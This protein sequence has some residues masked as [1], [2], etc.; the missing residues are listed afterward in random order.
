MLKLKC[1]PCLRKIAVIVRF[2]LYNCHVMET[3]NKLD[4]IISHW[5]TVE[6]ETYEIALRLGQERF[7]ERVA[8][9]ESVTNKSIKMLVLNVSLFGWFV[10]LCFSNNIE[11]GLLSLLSV[12]ATLIILIGLIMPKSVRDK[13]ISPAI[14]LP[15]LFDKSH[16]GESQI[17][18]VLF[19]ALSIVQQNI[20]VMSN[21]NS[22][23]ASKYKCALILSMVN[24]V[25]LSYSV[26]I[27]L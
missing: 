19:N 9:S 26:V 7:S 5:S 27:L 10:G 20:D 14:L 25:L 18:L 3:K 1:K 8:E 24:M 4:D 21:L 22:Q 17:K 11:I 16:R 6:K 23:R 13:G 15:D 2:F 12:F